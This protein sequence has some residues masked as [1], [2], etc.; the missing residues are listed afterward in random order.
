MSS[1]KNVHRENARELMKNIVSSRIR[2]SKIEH[3]VNA[4]THTVDQTL[5]A[6]EEVRDLLIP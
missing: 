3:T 2:I 6:I 5:A 1:N 4:L